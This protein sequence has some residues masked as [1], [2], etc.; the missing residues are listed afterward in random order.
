MNRACGMGGIVARPNAGAPGPSIDPVVLCP[1]LPL[2]PKR[3]T[4]EPSITLECPVKRLD[5]DMRCAVW[6]L[7]TDPVA[8]AVSPGLVD[9][10]RSPLV[11]E[12]T[13]S[14]SN[15]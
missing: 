15:H 10:G 11:G 6:L 3:D 8:I 1:S 2:R 14:S 9:H 4:Q 5:V 12:V 7:K 13:R